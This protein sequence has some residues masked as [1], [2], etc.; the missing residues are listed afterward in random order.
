VRIVI[1]ASTG[2]NTALNGLW[3]P[4]VDALKYVFD[5]TALIT[6]GL[7]VSGELRSTST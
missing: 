3:E 6:G 2:N 7:R 1:V 5:G 4:N